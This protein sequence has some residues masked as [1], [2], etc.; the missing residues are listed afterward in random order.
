M[1]LVRFSINSPVKVI[2]GGL[3]IILFGLIEFTRIPIQLTPDVDQP[4]LTVST[5]WLGASPEEI[6]REIVDRQE[7]VLK[8]L[9]GLLRMTSTSSR[10]TGAI[11]LEFPVGSDINAAMLKTSNALQ[12]VQGYPDTAER[13]VITSGDPRANAIAWITL[14]RRP[15][16][17]RSI[18][19]YRDLCTEVIKPAFERVPGVSA[20]N[21][22][23]GTERQLMVSVDPHRLA[24]RGISW[25]E[26]AEALRAENANISAGDLDEGK[27]KYLARTMGEFRSER[28]P[29]SIVVARRA[30]VPV[31]LRDVG[32]ARLGWKK[33]DFTVRNFGEPAIAINALRSSGS[34]VL[35][36]M[37]DLRKAIARLNQEVLEPQGVYLE[38]VYDE[39]VYI[40]SALDLVKSNLWMGSLLAVAVLFLFLSS[41]SSVFIIAAAIPVSVIGTFVAMSWMGRNLNVVSL[42][43][44]SFAVGMV[45]DNAIVVLENIDRLRGGGRSPADTAERGTSEVWGAVLASTLTT[46]AVFIPVLFIKEEVGQLFRDIALA[47]SSAVGLSLIVSVTLIPMM[48]ARM[49]RAHKADHLA[50]RWQELLVGV[51]AGWVAR[52]VH[53]ICGSWLARVAVVAFFTG[54]SI[55]GTLRLMPPLEYL[56][57]GNRNL[58][59]GMLLPPPGYN[60]RELENMAGRIE[61]NIAP[62]LMRYQG[63]TQK[64][65]EPA[66]DNFFF[67]AQ[68]QNVFLGA[69]AKNPERVN[70]LLPTLWSSIRDLPGV[71]AFFIQPS[72][73]ARGGRQGGSIVIEITGPEIPRVLELTRRIFF[74][75]PSALPGGQFRP[76][77]GLQL[78]NP[79]LRVTP[80]RELAVR[81]GFST[82][83]IGFAVDA[84][85]DGRKVSDFKYENRALDLMLEGDARYTQRTENLATLPLVSRQGTQ[86]TLGSIARVELTAG[87]DK[88]LHVERQR[89]VT[90]TVQPPPGMPLKAATQAIENQVLGPLRA[91]GELGAG[92]LARQAGAADDLA[93]AG[94]SLS[95][96]MLLALL[97]TYLLMAALFESFIHPF[98]IMFS[99]PLAGVGGMAGLV[100]VNRYIAPQPL[101]MLAMLG[102]IILIGTVVNNAIL[103]VHQALLL[104]REEGQNPRDAVSESVRTRVRPILMSVTTTVF[105]M[106]PLVLMPGAGSELY[107]GIGAVVVGGLTVSTVFTLFV[108]PAL[109]SLMLSLASLFSRKE[110]T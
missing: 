23:G 18:D 97:I 107:R 28:D 72:L 7:D 3:F 93:Q 110:T 4:R 41:F 65:S 57:T 109:F 76:D 104:M 90:I 75:L 66:I 71:I 87:S 34:N 16:N 79:E 88:I 11:T 67:V 14:K 77:P 100:L 40:Q 15:G 82:A 101:D 47:I 62:H 45:V 20:S 49:M 102:F 59:I 5:L 73:F 51:P 10:N 25:S 29:E 21:V 69:T 68:G 46:M 74:S 78:A 12:Q 37:A 33:P 56:P 26:I 95:F 31:F 54:V 1:D 9:D 105:G 81:A 36:V 55:W 86:T 30:G 53:R 64:P 24:E 85:L 2:V 48:A 70:G 50:A 43:G 63:K 44:I 38:Q 27:R 108:V 89:A 96:N 19:S 13:P 94:R 61:D 42:A 8:N 17:E 35:E 52:S 103:I 58:I 98:V 99:V 92:Y 32:S 60:L 22:Y 91:S 83:E 84:L 6:E 106:L 80:D 39:T